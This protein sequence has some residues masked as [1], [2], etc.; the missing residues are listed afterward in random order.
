M[1]CMLCV[2]IHIQRNYI[3]CSAYEMYE[4]PALELCELI[5]VTRE[6]QGNLHHSIG[7]NYHTAHSIQHTAC[8]IGHTSYIICQTYHIDAYTYQICNV[9]KPIL[10]LGIFETVLLA[11]GMKM[12]L[13][14]LLGI[15][16]VF[17]VNTSTLQQQHHLLR[18]SFPVISSWGHHLL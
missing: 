7:A 2:M 11:L 15:P 3:V 4:A 14:E 13:R 5:L 6:P 16:A 10:Q 17:V 12:E 9:S 1:L 18:F 8:S